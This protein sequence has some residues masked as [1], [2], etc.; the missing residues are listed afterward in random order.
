MQPITVAKFTADPTSTAQPILH[1]CGTCTITPVTVFGALVSGASGS[2][3][4]VAGA[5]GETT[6][7]SLTG[8]ASACWGEHPVSF[9]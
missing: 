8:S 9:P 2:P 5:G 6:C 4:D 3:L 1:N 7:A